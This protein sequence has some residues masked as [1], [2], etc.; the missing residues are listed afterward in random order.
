M[1]KRFLLLLSA[2]WL[3]GL[4]YL[5]VAQ[6]AALND[7]DLA[8]G[9][10]PAVGDT[11]LLTRFEDCFPHYAVSESSEKGKWWLRPYKTASGEGRMLCVE[12]RDTEDPQ[13][14]I[15]PA[16][17]YPMDLEGVYDIWVG[18]Y[19]PVY[20]GGID[21]KLTRDKTFFWINPAEDGLNQWPPAEE[22]LGR[23]VEVFYKTGDL[24]GQD[25]HLRQPH[26][27]YD[28]FWWGMCNAHVAYIKLVRRAPEDVEREVVDRDQ[29]QR[30]GVI[31]DHD[32]FS[33]VWQYGVEDIDCI[34]QQV[35]DDRYSDIEALNWCIGG[36]LSTNFP[37]P[38]TTGR[39]RGGARL[40]DKRAERV[41][42]NFE[43]RH[44]DILQVLVDRC[45]EVGMKI[46]ASHRANVHYRSSNVWD[47]HPEW[48]LASRKGLDYANPE[49]RA[50]YR[51]FL[52]YIAENYDIDGLTIDY[53][54][55]RQHFNPGQENQFELMNAYVRDLRVG[56]DRIG[57][58]RGK[59]LDLNVSF[60]TG[61]WYDAQKPE[62]Q[63]L[64]V[65]TWVNEGLVDRIMPEGRQVMKYVEMCRGNPVEC[66]PRKTWAMGFTGEKLE[67]N[68]HDPTPAEDKQDRP[69]LVH[70]AP[71]TVAAGILKWYDAGA[72]GVFLF[73]E[74]PR[75]T[76]RHLPYP[77]VLRKEVESGQPY[78]R[79]I[80]E[81]VEWLAGHN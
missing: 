74:T 16:L 5:D 35:E 68:P 53:S 80:G 66:Y 52:L 19:R 61:T 42:K 47:E 57:G 28:S 2:L 45:H 64:D 17:T 65:Q 18:T 22:K 37:H 70:M 24:T 81:K 48:H 23:I 58:E 73:N 10:A 31:V 79:Q 49:V 63:G 25:I 78:G 55:H 77:D 71:L 12:Q 76:L 67:T 26:G 56:L 60:T 69:L 62:Q 6:G 15:A 44:V 11:V 75:V 41:F 59:H 38:M 27:T 54:R 29:T 33:Y 14:C 50:F 39:I 21:I 40:G 8:A 30:K 36:S 20:G 72:D 4:P 32:G 1:Q 9:R 43:S 51:D 3:T 7:D 13:S 46:Y 34:L